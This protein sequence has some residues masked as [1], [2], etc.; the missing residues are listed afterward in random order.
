[1]GRNL[2]ICISLVSIVTLSL[3]LTFAMSCDDFLIPFMHINSFSFLSHVTKRV[4]CKYYSDDIINNLE[5][6]L[7]SI[8]RNL[9]SQS[10]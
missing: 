3:T 9:A 6:N 8:F 1:M 10:L 4:M 5:S 2:T 7:S